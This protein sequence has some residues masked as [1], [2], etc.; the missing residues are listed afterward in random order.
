MCIR[1][2]LVWSAEP[3][4]AVSNA[5]APSATGHPPDHSRDHGCGGRSALSEPCRRP[6]TTATAPSRYAVHRAAVTTAEDR[7]IGR[8]PGA[9]PRGPRPGFAADGP[10]AATSRRRPNERLNATGRSRAR[11]LSEGEALTAA[12][13]SDQSAD[14]AISEGQ[15]DVAILPGTVHLTEPAGSGNPV[16]KLARDLE[17]PQPRTQHVNGESNLDAPTPRQR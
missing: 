13:G 4:G 15:P 11:A 2:R 7:E 17:H 14:P 8:S 1:D 5:R 3:I 16:L 6:S 10:A 12:S 9:Q